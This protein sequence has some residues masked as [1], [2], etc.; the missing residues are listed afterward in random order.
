M[1]ISAKVSEENEITP[2]ANY[3][4][5]EQ[6]GS[7][8]W[9]PRYELSITQCRVDVTWF[10]FDEQTCN[11]TFESWV[12]DNS[13]LKLRAYESIDFRTFLPPD[14]WLLTGISFRNM[15][16]KPCKDR[17][18]RPRSPVSEAGSPQVTLI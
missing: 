10:P 17:M 18:G 13:S 2:E 7:C 4:L 5:I 12:L 16:C 6:N 9:Y 8:F 1:N 14:E 3:V 15:H 11:V